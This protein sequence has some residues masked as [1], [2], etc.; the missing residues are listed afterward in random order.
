MGEIRNTAM[1]NGIYKNIGA[2]IK[3]AHRLVRLNKFIYQ[4]WETD[5]EG[6]YCKCQKIFNTS[7]E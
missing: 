3:F 2:D 5:D 4:I 1:S 7:F 6:K